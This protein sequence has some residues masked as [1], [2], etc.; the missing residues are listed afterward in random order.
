M[1]K[2]NLILTTISYKSGGDLPS[3]IVATLPNVPVGISSWSESELRTEKQN[4]A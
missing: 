4:N 1:R 2:S 3:A